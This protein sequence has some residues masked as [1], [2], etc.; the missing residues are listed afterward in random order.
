MSMIGLLAHP[1]DK[2]VDLLHFRRINQVVDIGII[3]T[4]KALLAFQLEGLVGPVAKAGGHRRAVAGNRHHGCIEIAFL[5]EILVF[6]EEIEIGR[7]SSVAK[8]YR[9]QHSS[10]HAIWAQFQGVDLG[11]DSQVEELLIQLFSLRH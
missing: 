6:E 5:G 9:S 7:V 1:G 2:M 11:R 4:E 10:L 3:Y 8:I